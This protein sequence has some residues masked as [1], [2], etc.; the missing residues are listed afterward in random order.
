M[1]RKLRW[2]SA[3]LCAV[4]VIGA[5]FA[6]PGTVYRAD[7]VSSL[8]QLQSKLDALK[9]EQA[10]LDAQLKDLK[11]QQQSQAAYQ[12]SLQLKIAN[13]Q[14]QID[15]LN[16]QI[17]GFD[18]QISEKQAQIADAETK[19]SANYGKLKERLK[20]IYMLGEASKLDILFSASNVTD[21]LNKAQFVQAISDHDQSIISTLRTQSDS[22]KAEK[23]SIEAD[24]AKLAD[25]KTQ[26]DTQKSQLQSAMDESER[27]SSQ[28]QASQATTTARQ[29]EINEAFAKADE[30]IKQ[31]W[32]AYYKEQEANANASK[33]VST[34][35]FMWPM[36]G[37][38]RRSNIT[39][40]FGGV[41]N[42]RGMDISGGG[43]YG[44]PI[45]AADSGVVAV[46][47]YNNAVYGIYVQIDHGNGVATLY[48][49]TS[50][51]AVK[52]GQTVQK[53]QTIAY[54]GSSGMSTGPHLHFGVLIRGT[55]VDP[56]QY[57]KLS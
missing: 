10:K 24:R 57:F 22:I 47:S 50:G 55:P 56:L 51:L 26:Y 18:A 12:Q 29:K 41:N 43:V 21:F 19:I 34:G 25:A 35:S 31:W 42:H 1:N 7:A 40:Y 48:G 39:Q 6:V 9:Q 49:H 53:G 32:I 30:E 8:T 4:L 46:A 23:E 45:V 28:L 52:V 27:I 14:G 38:S 54:V 11:D 36:P 15:N 2:V 17:S 20:A 3:L 5:V 13:A 33:P 16:A 44:K 37:Y